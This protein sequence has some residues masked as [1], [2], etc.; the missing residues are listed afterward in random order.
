MRNTFRQTLVLLVLLVAIPV[1][2]QTTPPAARA[3]ATA[4]AHAAASAPTRRMVTPVGY[5]LGPGDIV[6]ITVY[7]HPGLTLDTALGQDGR[8]NF[9]LVGP[10]KLGGLTPSQA[11][12]ALENSLTSGGFIKSP[13]VNVAIVQYRS[14]QV[15][16]LGWVGHPGVFHLKKASHVTDA[17]ALA[18]G[19]VPAG[20][21]IIT[22]IREVKGKTEYQQI[23]ALKLFQ[24]GGSKLNVIV[25]RGDILYVPRQPRFY[26]YGQVQRPGYFRLRQHMTVVQALSVG[27]GLTNRGTD[28]GIK[29][30]RQDPNGAVHQ[31]GAKLTMPVEPN[32]V[33]Y[34]PESLF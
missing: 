24:P 30:M 28:S 26:I 27:G 23:N 22:L 31:I 16:V 5:R 21:D 18:G 29:I 15:T 1:H 13:Q 12:T 17:L 33:I 9:P 4:P 25:Q 19:I 34:V 32:D 6:H 14:Q 2:A 20:S 8:I 7:Q 10:I 3:E 11:E